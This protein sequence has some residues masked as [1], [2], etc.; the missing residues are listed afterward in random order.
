MCR[1]RAISGSGF[2]PP[3]RRQIRRPCRARRGARL[4][5]VGAVCKCN[6][7]LCRWREAARADH[8]GARIT[9]RGAAT[10]SRRAGLSRWPRAAATGASGG[11]LPSVAGV[12]GPGARGAATHADG[13]GLLE[14]GARRVEIDEVAVV[15]REGPEGDRA[16]RRRDGERRRGLGRGR[17]CGLRLGG[18]CGCDGDARRR[19]TRR[20][21]A[22]RAPPLSPSARRRQRASAPPPAA[23]PAARRRCGT[24]RRPRRC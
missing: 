15:E 22:R 21:R 2:A 14:L 7:D 20:R 18:G 24:S 6:G 13:V 23:A 1:C 10:A 17:G 5:R 16:D 8:A 19:P 4:C 11:A 12:Q 9:G 3:H